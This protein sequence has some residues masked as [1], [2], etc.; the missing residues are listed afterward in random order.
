[1]GYMRKLRT[2]GVF[3]ASLNSHRS[4]KV[5]NYNLKILQYRA[6]HVAII[7]FFICRQT[8]YAELYDIETAAV[9]TDVNDKL[10]LHFSEYSTQFPAK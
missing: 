1:M 8:K 10:E 5:R 4:N 6:P 9:A 7:L 3:T 2:E